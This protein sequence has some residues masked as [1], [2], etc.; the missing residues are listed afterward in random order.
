VRTHVRL[1]REG[2]RPVD[3]LANIALLRANQSSFEE[4][5]GLGEI[6]TGKPR[7]R[8]RALAAHPEASGPNL[9]GT[10]SVR[11]SRVLIQCESRTVTKV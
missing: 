11:E 9:C 1:A 6:S 7:P 3:T 2:I 8:R 4:V 5:V 10:W